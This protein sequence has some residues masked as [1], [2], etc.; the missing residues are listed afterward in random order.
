MEWVHLYLMELIHP[1]LHD[2]ILVSLKNNYKVYQ[3][4]AP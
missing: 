2:K 1:T 4:G 3:W